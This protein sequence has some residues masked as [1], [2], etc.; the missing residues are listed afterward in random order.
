MG[1]L[2]ILLV[3]FFLSL[4]DDGFFPPTEPP[5]IAEDTSRVEQ[6]SHIVDRSRLSTMSAAGADDSTLAPRRTRARESLE[7]TLQPEPVQPQPEAEPEPL[8]PEPDV[9]PPAPLM[10]ETHLPPMAAHSDDEDNDHHG[11]ESDG[12]DNREDS[13]DEPA[14]NDQ[15]DDAAEEIFDQELPDEE[16]A[17]DEDVRYI[18]FLELT[19]HQEAYGIRRKVNISGF[20]LH[21]VSVA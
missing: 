12:E 3:Y 7:T 14:A 15:I 18:H 6:D 11:F 9:P 20:M 1:T 4:T 10:P 19:N 8:L 13:D 21:L 17:Q 5:S 2:Y 16:P